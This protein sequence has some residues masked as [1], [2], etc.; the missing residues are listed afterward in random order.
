V[1]RLTVYF[2]IIA[3][4]VYGLLLVVA[5]LFTDRLMFWPPGPSYKADSIQFARV[6]EGRADSI[7]LLHL[8]NANARYAIL[9]SHGN[10]EDLG[11]LARTLSVVHQAGFAVVAYDY[12]GYG[13]SSAGP[14]TALKAAEDAEA[15]YQYA[16][17]TLGISPDR[18][19]LYGRSLGSG[20][21]IQLA[22]N[23]QVAGVILEGA[24]TSPSAVLTRARIL[25]F[26]N[27]RN[28]ANIRRL[29]APLLVIHADRDEVI[30]FAHGKRLYAL[31]PEP[32]Q[33]LWVQGSGHNDLLTVAGSR[34]PEALRDFARLVEEHGETKETRA[35]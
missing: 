33:A 22:V 11:H 21:T 17:S 13:L 20:P 3:L 24:F 10:A 2:L 32:K 7:A 23:H 29:R 27:F 19:I 5:L 31:A 25:P 28:A 15:A 9:Y 14:P 26:G 30:P 8:P 35:P 4:C 16:V 6:G 18:L 1:R 12:R 34:Y